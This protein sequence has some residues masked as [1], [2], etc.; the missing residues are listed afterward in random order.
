MGTSQ[1]QLEASIL[2]NAANRLEDVRKRWQP[3][4]DHELDDALLYNQKL[5]TVF[6][7][8][9]ADAE[10]RLPDDLRNKIGSIA[11]FVFKRTFELMA[12]PEPAKIDALVTINRNLAAGLLTRAE[13]AGES[14][15]QGPTPGTISGSV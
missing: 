2:L 12:K 8:E 7:A 14:T 9:V 5:W 10:G 13:T 11:V 6:A 3:E 15:P 1:R 4:L